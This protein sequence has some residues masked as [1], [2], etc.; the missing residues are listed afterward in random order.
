MRI[1]AIRGRDLASLA[2]RFEVDLAGEPLGRA[3]L[4]AI[5]GPTGAGKTTL[6]DC[7]CLALFDKVPRLHGARGVRIG[8]PGADMDQAL[9]SVDVRNLLRRGCAAAFAEVDFIGS[10]GG[11]YRSSWRVRRAR[12]RIDGKLQP[13]TMMLTDLDRGAEL[14]DTRKSETLRRIRERLGLDFE[15]FCRSVLLA[16]GEFAAFMKADSSQRSELLER[17]TGTRIYS[18]LSKAA[19]QASNDARAELE[20][21]QRGMES[22]KPLAPGALS[23]LHGREAE[24]ERVRRALERRIEQLRRDHPWYEQLEKL[25][26]FQ[27]EAVQAVA[28][29]ERDWKDLAE[30]RGLL[31]E[32]EAA[33][34]LAAPLADCDKL[35]AEVAQRRQQMEKHERREIEF[36]KRLEKIEHLLA[37]A[38]TALKT[39]KTIWE[40]AR[41]LL[42]K[43]TALDSRIEEKKMQRDAAHAEWERA[44]AEAVESQQQCQNLEK[45]KLEIAA[46]NKEIDAWKAEHSGD[47]TLAGDWKAWEAELVRFLELIERRSRLTGEMEKERKQRND[48]TGQFKQKQRRQKEIQ[49]RKNLAQERLARAKERHQLLREDDW[50][51]REQKLESGARVV[52]EAHRLAKEFERLNERQTA[53]LAELTRR[54]LEIMAAIEEKVRVE[55]SAR[56]NAIQL[57]EAERACKLAESRASFKERRY[58]L[59]VEGEPCPLCGATS[60]PY[61]TGRSSEN[62]LV[63]QQKLRVDELRGKRDYLLK[64]ESVVAEHQKAQKAG[65]AELDEELA[66]LGQSSREFLNRWD[67]LCNET[68]AASLGLPAVPSVE[69]TEEVMA[70]IKGEREAVRAARDTRDKAQEERDEAQGILNEA[71]EKLAELERGFNQTELSLAKVRAQLIGLERQWQQ[72]EGEREAF[73][74]GLVQIYQ[75]REFESLEAEPAAFLAETKDRV[76][77]WKEKEKLSQQLGRDLTALEKEVAVALAQSRERKKGLA[78]RRKDLDQLE[79]LL[80]GLAEERGA[81]FE[82]QAV[83]DVEARLKDDLTARERGLEEVRQNREDALRE[84]SESAQIIAAAR[85]LLLQTEARWAE[86]E[87]VL[88]ERLAEK[89][90]DEPA[91]RHRLRFDEDW[92]EQRRQEMKRAES[93]LAHARSVLSERGSQLREHQRGATPGQSAEALA[94]A[95]KDGQEALKAQTRRV[96]ESRMELRLDEEKRRKADERMPQ[97]EA[98][99]ERTELWEVMHDLI[100]SHDGKKF[101]SFAQSLTLDALIAGANVHMSDL[102]PRYNL[103]RVPNQDLEIQVVDRHMGDEVRSLQS[104]SGGESFLVSLAL[105]LGLST[106]SSQRTR[107][108]SLFIDEGFGTLDVRTLDAALATLDTLQAT[109]RQIGIISHIN[110]IA[111]RVGVCVHVVRT[112]R[113]SS[114]VEVRGI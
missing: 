56:E 12:G 76:R 75:E 69:E 62:E 83:N 59:L 96:T 63:N 48:L 60:H 66:G 54:G 64:L 68:E 1:L 71:G 33:Q 99:Q 29:K 45:R 100:G 26:G 79:R 105:A 102:E 61:R 43:A 39:A 72:T 11:R 58:E 31:R 51:T 80:S 107:I 67:G 4:F 88:K 98:Q 35:R 84:R 103:Q 46:Q 2:G 25:R 38:E 90:W 42:A 87:K 34:K 65:A 19:H 37:Q 108:D 24:A 30:G 91:L 55:A 52:D 85:E 95:M 74:R 14:S 36:R 6:L 104:L 9:F 28:E 73:R 57:A 10:D 44:R 17:M 113:D 8:E 27:R 89:R 97:I 7:A 112:S 5:V 86:G 101:R 111:E 82:G 78:P 53:A 21:L 109:G 114:R 94:G 40:E 32:V 47:G 15:Q 49:E 93:D 22:L 41:P 106:L 20:K 70:K 16:Q 13:Q 3:G 92:I 50:R 18:S 81:Y 110:D 23:E 77:V